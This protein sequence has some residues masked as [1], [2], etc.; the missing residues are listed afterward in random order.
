MKP[1]WLSLAV[2][3]LF[4]IG[5]HWLGSGGPPKGR[6]VSNAMCHVCHMNYEEERL[7]VRHAKVGVGCVTCHGRS[8]AHCN[9]ENNVTP[10]DVLYPH[11][12]VN[13]ACTACHAARQLARAEC[14]VPILAGTATINRFCTNCHGN[15]RLPRRTVRWDKTTRALLPKD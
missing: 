1:F 3:S 6:P 9:D 11:E 7:A 10:P 14:H 13:S 15:H 2:A 5:C 8:D 12:K 4:V